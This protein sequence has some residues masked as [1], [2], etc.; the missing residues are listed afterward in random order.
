MRFLFLTFFVLTFSSAFS[1]IKIGL[2]LNPGLAW[3]RSPNMTEALDKMNEQDP[4]MQYSNRS[5]NGLQVGL[6][7]Y[8]EYI[9]SSKL[10]FLTEL[11]F[12]YQ[13]TPY[14]ITSDYDLRDANGTGDRT[15]VESNAKIKGYYISVPLLTKY[16]LLER[17]RIYGIGGFSFNLM[18]QPKIISRETSTFTQYTVNEI[19]NSPN[20]VSTSSSAK[21]DGAGMFNTQFVIGAGKTFRFAGKSLDIELR[22]QL[23]LL[24]TSL[25]TSDQNFYDNTYNNQY[26]TKQGTADLST[27]TGVNV[28]DFRNGMVMFSIRYQLKYID[29][30]DDE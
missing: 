17:Q 27:Q 15:Q 26:F 18:F 6:G 10:T 29:N 8:A 23:P 21:L 19:V 7:G 11:T 12:N 25:V 2:K 3:Y 20:V 13:N 16:V 5:V 9:K 1:Q 30:S 24:R 22:Y 4:Q 14:F 28:N